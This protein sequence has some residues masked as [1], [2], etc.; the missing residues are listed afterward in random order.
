M[1]EVRDAP[2]MATK[3]ASAAAQASGDALAAEARPQPGVAPAQLA[4]ARRFRLSSLALPLSLIVLLVVWETYVATF[5]PP[6]YILPAPS[7]IL[8]TLFFGLSR[9]L[10]DRAG[11]WFHLR[12]TLGG[13]LTGYLFGCSAGALLG[14]L[15]AE[16]RLLERILLPYAVGLQ[17]L[18]KVAIAPLILIWFG[19]GPTSKIVIAS[20][21]TFFPLLINTYVGLSLVDRDYLLLMRSLRANRLHMLLKVKLKAALPMIF[22]GLDMS[23]VYAI[24]G[25][26]VA[27]FVG[28]EA[29]LGVMII[30]AQTSSDSAS[31][32]AALVILGTV[33]FLFHS[34]V[35]WLGHR[36]VFWTRRQDQITATT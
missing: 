12:H 9:G 14:I 31:V 29:G 3:E 7:A 33:G 2:R 19:F 21:L 34:L 10:D 8:R 16:F 25:A 32:F 26:I 30:Q 5:R 6:S 18:P 27:E 24:L 36:L 20:L 28:S 13:A 11:Y 15:I 4:T 1:A 23:T 35:Q 22:A 17:S